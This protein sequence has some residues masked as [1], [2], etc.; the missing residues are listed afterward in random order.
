MGTRS[1]SPRG[2]LRHSIGLPE[3]HTTQLDTACQHSAMHWRLAHRFEPLLA[4]TSVHR[5]FMAYFVPSNGNNFVAL[6]VRIQAFICCNITLTTNPV[7]LPFIAAW[8]YSWWHISPAA[9]SPSLILLCK[10]HVQ[11][12]CMHQHEHQIVKGAVMINMDHQMQKPEWYC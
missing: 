10:G 1:P 11:C 4:V 12:H 5:T 3:R 6:P 9:F 8:L 7:Y 2:P